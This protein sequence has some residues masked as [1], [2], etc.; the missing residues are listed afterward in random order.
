MKISSEFGGFVSQLLIGR[1]VDA[2]SH[3]LGATCGK[4]LGYCPSDSCRS[5]HEHYLANKFSHA[6]LTF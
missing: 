2:A 5:R 4:A 3:H 6:I 1:R